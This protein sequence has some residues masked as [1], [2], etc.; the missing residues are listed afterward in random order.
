MNEA[1]NRGAFLLP[2]V[3]LVGAHPPA[4]PNLATVGADPVDTDKAPI[5]T[6]MLP[7]PSSQTPALVTLDGIP[8][9]CHLSCSSPHI[10][11]PCL[12][13]GVRNR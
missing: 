3:P 11:Q 9:S 13:R 10:I 2:P 12:F 5:V 7:H 6:K 4:S 8:P 1:G